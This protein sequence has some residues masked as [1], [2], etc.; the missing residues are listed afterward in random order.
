MKTNCNGD[1]KITKEQL[2]AEVT[3]Y[4]LESH[5]FNGSPVV[6]CKKRNNRNTIKQ[7]VSECVKE[8]KIEVVFGDCHPNPHIKAFLAD[9]IDEQLKKISTKL[10]EGACLYPHPNHLKKTVEKSLYNEKP[11]TLCLALGEPQL[12]YKAFE[13][14]VLENYKNDPRY[15]YDN[16]DIHGKISISNDFYESNDV[17][18]SDKILLQTFGFCYDEDLDRFVAVYLRYLSYL[19]SEHQQIWYS[20][21]VEFKTSLHP[22]YWRTT[23]GHWPKKISIFSAFLAEQ[24]AINDM[25]AQMDKPNLFINTYSNQN[26]PKE[27]C[28]LIRPTL[29]EYNNFIHLLDKL[30]SENV[31]RDFFKDEIPYEKEKKRKDGKIIVQI[32]GSLKLL[33]E[34]LAKSFK[35]S[36][37][38]LDNAIRDMLKA[39]KNIRKLRQ[40]P[41]H[42]L[43][44]DIFDNKYI[45]EQRILFDDAY[46]GVRLI[47]LILENHPLVHNV[48][49]NDLVRDGKI[50]K[51]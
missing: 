46:K 44:K 27:F 4:Y 42:S 18:K 24:R 34:W 17:K 7:I 47:R 30:I 15:Y 48:D 43:Q 35:A 14:S 1:Y 21:H 40:K 12:S 50:W 33:E 29:K 51:I 25:C 36:N 49:I 13:L 28:F 45:H 20:K 8:Q 23:C 3:K 22:D 6:D 39:F 37:K 16:D 32:K 19:S 26:K 38:E 41:A 5:Q 2:V 10:F 31:N 9:P 11:Y